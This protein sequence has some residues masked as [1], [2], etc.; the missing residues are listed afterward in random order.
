[1]TGRWERALP[2]GTPE[3]GPAGSVLHRAS[4]TTLPQVR[5]LNHVTWKVLTEFGHPAAIS[6]PRVVSRA[7]APLSSMGREQRAHL[8]WRWSW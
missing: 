7:P 4:R 1:M 2:E 5:I 6:D 8:V 3:D